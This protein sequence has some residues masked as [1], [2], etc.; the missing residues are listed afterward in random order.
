MTWFACMDLEASQNEGNTD[1]K[2]TGK[3]LLVLLGF[4]LGILGC[5]KDEAAHETTIGELKIQAALKVIS[6]WRFMEDYDKYRDTMSTLRDELIG[7]NDTVRRKKYI[8]RFAEIVRAYPLDATDAGTRRQQLHA[9]CEMSRSAAL[10]AARI[11]YVDREWDIKLRCLRR[12]KD[13]LK[14]LDDY[15]E[16]NG[17]SSEFKGDRNGWVEYRKTV[18]YWYNYYDQSFSRNFGVTQTADFLTYERWLAIRSELEELLGHKV[19][20]WKSVLEKWEKQQASR[21]HD[22]NPEDGIKEN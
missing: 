3:T 14:K 1:M 16:G 4:M 21:G 12:V 9:F 20:V 10:R 8:N 15:L 2:K 7:L 5:R 18:R 19:K 17:Q 13:E 11:D 6:N 22:V